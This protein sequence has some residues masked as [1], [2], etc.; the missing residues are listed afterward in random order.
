ML[1]EEPPAP[2]SIM[3]IL[4]RARMRMILILRSNDD[5]KIMGGKKRMLKIKT[6][7]D[8]YYFVF[9]VPGNSRKKCHVPKSSCV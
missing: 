9:Y 7:I 2:A 8:N 3:K 4:R 1:W 5:K 6:P